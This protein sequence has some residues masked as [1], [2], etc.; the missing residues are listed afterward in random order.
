MDLAILIT[1]LNKPRMDVIREAIFTTW[2]MDD[3]DTDYIGYRNLIRLWQQY[4]MSEK[5][6]LKE[7]D[8]LK[9][10]VINELGE[11]IFKWISWNTTFL[12]RN[13]ILYKKYR[14]TDM[15][16]DSAAKLM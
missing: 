2:D 11:D 6:S 13:E 3:F 16:V 5:E 4:L 7:Y 15:V 10:Y 8:R 1:L 14:G 9:A 12:V